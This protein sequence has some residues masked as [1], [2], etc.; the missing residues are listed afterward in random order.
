[1][2]GYR[3]AIFLF[4]LLIA[5]PYGCFPKCNYKLEEINNKYYHISNADRIVAKFDVSV[6]KL[7]QLV[8]SIAEEL[9]AEGQKLIEKEIKLFAVIDRESGIKVRHSYNFTIENESIR[10]GL[11][12]SIKGLETII[13]SFLSIWYEFTFEPVFDEDGVNYNIKKVNDSYLIDRHDTKITI[14]AM[15]YNNFKT[16]KANVTNQD[17][18]ISIEANFE[19]TD[20]GL[21]LSKYISNNENEKFSFRFKAKYSEIDGYFWPKEAVIINS[22][23]DQEDRIELKFKSIN[24]TKSY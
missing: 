7:N 1:M 8:N 11:E 2:K 14:S 23:N 6:D 20:R 9:P 19:N 3:L 24:I 22:F 18:K 13:E 17:N 16:L 4:F 15:V 5:V 21:L 10:N 12:R